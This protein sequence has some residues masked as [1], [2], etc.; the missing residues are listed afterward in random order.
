MNF[1]E[2]SPY[3]VAHHLERLK[4]LR[5]GGEIFPVFVQA[6]LLDACNFHCF[7]CS[8]REQGVT[9]KNML[10]FEKLKD[11]LSFAS[12]RGLKAVE[13][14]GGGEPTLYP[15]F[16]ELLDFT[17][18]LGLEF[19]L[20]TNGSHLLDVAEYLGGASWI[21]VSVD[22]ASPEVFSSVHGVSPRVFSRVIDGIKK[23]RDLL[24]ETTIGLSF[25]VT[26]RNLHEI[27]AF[28]DLGL[29]LGVDNVRF[30]PLYGKLHHT[31]EPFVENVLELLEEVESKETKSFR[32][33]TLKHR[34]TEPWRGH[35][36]EKCYYPL[37]VATLAADG[38]FYP[39][40][41]L[42]NISTP[43]GSY[44]DPDCLWRG[45]KDA[46]PTA[47]CPPCWMDD[48]NEFISYILKENPKHVNFV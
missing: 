20:V 29:S 39:C 33:F 34:F 11:F 35:K 47:S 13:Y 4:T 1:E 3:K 48:K 9:G 41:A 14:T 15:H 42:K 28:V 10:G 16:K 8:T 46:L 21:R 44:T 43:L 12:K 31:L 37:F 5:S 25:V 7:Y 23:A 36:T 27:P 19:A 18:T 40:C 32:V 30:T 38:N 6:D 26:P 22:A 17:R 24:P 2:Y 45:V